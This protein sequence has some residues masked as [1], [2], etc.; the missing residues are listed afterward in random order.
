MPGT[1]IFKPIKA[2]L[3]NESDSFLKMD[4][5]CSIIVGSQEATGKVCKNGGK[6]PHWEDSLILR[7]QFEPSCLLK[8]K[9]KEWFKSDSTLGLVEI[10]LR[11]IESQGR[12]T[13]WYKLSY[14]NKPAG[15]ILLDAVFARDSTGT[16][17]QTPQ[18]QSYAQPTINYQNYGQY[19]YHPPTQSPSKQSLIGQNVISD[20][21]Y[22]TIPGLESNNPLITFPHISHHISPEE[23]EKLHSRQPERYQP[24]T[25]VVPEQKRPPTW[26]GYRPPV[27]EESPKKSVLTPEAA[28]LGIL[29]DTSAT[30]IS[31]A[32]KMIETPPKGNT[33]MLTE[34]P[35]KVIKEKENVIPQQVIKGNENVTP[36]KVL[37]EKENVIPQQVIKEKEYVTPQKV[38]QQNIQRSPISCYPYLGGVNY[39]LG[40]DGKGF[41]PL[42]EVPEVRAKEK[43]VRKLSET[44]GV[45][46]TS[47]TNTTNANLD[48]GAVGTLGDIC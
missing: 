43:N 1:I 23:Y 2:T 16:Y 41:K 12:L 3:L 42:Y 14:D 13:K 6:S 36:Q 4:P 29:S 40:R 34:T 26:E 15:E 24:V 19:L 44:S 11:E 22:S 31:P 38:V 20:I 21:N 10:D 33:E 28:S 46:R 25:R 17:K 5:Y 30:N 18:Q 8:I 35:P 37:K 32:G 45:T 48:P 9:D 39:L 27:Y 7:R 47:S